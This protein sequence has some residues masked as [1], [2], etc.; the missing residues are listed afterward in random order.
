[1]H[2]HRLAE[3]PEHAAVARAALHEP[4][5]LLE[6]A[7]VAE[8]R[9][10]QALF[11]VAHGSAGALDLAR[12]HAHHLAVGRGADAH[13]EQA[14]VEHLAQAIREVEI[15]VGQRVA[16]DGVRAARHGD[17]VVRRHEA[18]GDGGG[19][20]IG[21]RGHDRRR[22]ARRDVRL[23]IRERQALDDLHAVAPRAEIEEAHAIGRGRQ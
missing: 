21:R 17:G 23:D 6:Q 1:M 7:V 5:H 15:L 9:I 13:L 20:R 14:A 22:P 3:E 4:Q 10:D 16:I 19:G 11:H 18:Q 12:E 8:A 2:R